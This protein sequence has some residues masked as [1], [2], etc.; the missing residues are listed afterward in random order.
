MFVTARDMRVRAD[1]VTLAQEGLPMMGQVVRHIQG[2]ADLVTQVREDRNMMVP[3]VRPI[4]GLAVRGTTDLV[5]LLMMVLG[6]LLTPVLGDLVMRVLVV[7]VIQ[8]QEA[9]G[10]TVQQFVNDGHIKK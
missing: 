2:Q 1:L 10:K 6:D 4:R 7:R 8:D 3:V 5:G 9:L